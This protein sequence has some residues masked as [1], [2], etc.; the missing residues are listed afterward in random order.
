MKFRGG[1]AVTLLSN[2]CISTQ[3]KRVQD[4]LEKNSKVVGESQIYR[5]KKTVLLEQE[6]GDN[7]EKSKFVSLSFDSEGL[8]NVVGIYDEFKHQMI[9]QLNNYHSLVLQHLGQDMST[10]HINVVAN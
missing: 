9:K 8:A 10:S 4:Y 6:Y 5:G 7:G 3:L 2:G 1:K